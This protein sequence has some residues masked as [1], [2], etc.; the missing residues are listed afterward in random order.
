MS[1]RSASDIELDAPSPACIESLEMAWSI[2][3]NAYGGE[4][5]SAPT[6]W[7]EAAERWRDEHWHPAL[8]A[9][10]TDEAEG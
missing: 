4:W 3:A 2:I 8:A 6:E 9:A 1:D 7:R 10:M 5:E